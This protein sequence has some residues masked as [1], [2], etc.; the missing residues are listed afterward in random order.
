M[1]AF[2]LLECHYQLLG[3]L[4]PPAGVA[5]QAPADHRLDV[6]GHPHPQFGQAPRRSAEPLGEDFGLGAS[7]EGERAGEHLEEEQAQGVNVA[8]GIHLFSPGLL[9]GE[10]LQ[11]ANQGP[12][13]GK[14]APVGQAC[15]PK[16]ADVGV[17]RLIHQHVFGL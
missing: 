15:Y 5:F 7:R 13:A 8:A 14:P 12:G 2:L 6:T 9:R 1:R 3:A 4:E 16:I 17:P 11:G 10:V